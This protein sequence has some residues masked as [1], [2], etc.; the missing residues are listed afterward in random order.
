M[1]LSPLHTT[2]L[3]LIVLLGWLAP[4]ATALAVG[5]SGQVTV[6]NKDGQPL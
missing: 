4:A 2:I 5:I 3:G 1:R 6:L